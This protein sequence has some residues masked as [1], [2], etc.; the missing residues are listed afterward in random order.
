MDLVLYIIAALIAFVCVGLIAD[1]YNTGNGKMPNSIFF[2]GLYTA[3]FLIYT[4]IH[5]A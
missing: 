1:W 4:V 5:Y 3:S 2:A